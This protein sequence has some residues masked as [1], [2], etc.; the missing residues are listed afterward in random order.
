L[1]PAFTERTGGANPLNGEDIGNYSTVS[2]G[3]VDGD[4]DLDLVMGELNGK[5]R[6]FEASSPVAVDLS[7]SAG[8]GTETGTTVITVTATADSA[9][10]GAQTVTVAAS[11]TGITA[12]DFTLS[13][14]TITIADGQTIGTVTFTIVDD[15]QIEGAETATLTISN[16][17]ASITLGST[18][19]QNVAIT[20]NDSSG[21]VTGT[22]PVAGSFT[23]DDDGAG[24]VELRD[25]GG[26]LIFSTPDTGTIVINGTAGDDTLTIDFAGGNLTAT[27]TFNGLGQAG[28]G[29]ALVLTGG[30]TFNTASFT[31]DSLNDGSIDITGNGTISYTGLEP[32]TSTITATNVTLNLPNV[33]NPDTVLRDSAAAG[34]TELVGSTFETIAFTNPT[35]SLTI[36]GG[37]AADTISIEGLDAAWVADLNILATGV[38]D[39]STFQTTATD[40]G[41]G[42]LDV[43]T[44][45]ITVD[46]GV[47]TN[48]GS[49]ILV[50]INKTD[51]DINAAILT[52]GGA[53]DVSGGR[54][55]GFSAS[56]SI[57]TEAGSTAT[58][59]IQAD[60]LPT[61]V[62]GITMA[63][64]SFVD[65]WGGALTVL[66][67]DD[68]A[69][70]L[71]RSSATVRITSSGGAITD[72]DAGSGQDIDRGGSVALRAVT[73][74]G[75]DADGLET[76]LGTLAAVTESG[77]I[78]LTNTG[79]LIIGTVNGLS[80]VT[81]TDA[82]TND[83]GNDN[84][85]IVANSPLTV[86]QL[87]I[88]NDGGNIVLT[89]QGNAT[90]DDLTLDA[91]VTAT[92]GN[93]NITL[94]AGDSIL[95]GG[96]TD[97]DV[98][99][100]G[101]GAIDYNANDDAGTAGAGDG[102][103]AGAITMADG[104]QAS[105]GTGLI[106]M[107]AF[108]DIT[109]G[110]VATNNTTTAAIIVT[111]TNGDIVD[112]GDSDTFDFSA[113]SGSAR[114]T[115]TAATGIGDGTPAAAGGAAD[116][117]IE[118]RILD[119][120]ASVTGTG[121][122]DID[123]ND[124]IILSDVDTANGSIQVDAAG[125]VN[126]DDVESTT[127]ADANDIRI[128]TTTG[129][130][131]IDRINVG[132]GTTAANGDVI[133]EATAGAITE[134]NTVNAT[135]VVAGGFRVVA[136]NG[137]VGLTGNLIETSISTLEGSSTGGGFFVTNSRSFA[138]ND[139]ALGLTDTTDGATGITSAGTV[140]LNSTASGNITLE[141]PVS[142]NAQLVS[143]NSN[144]S[145]V[146]NASDAAR[147]I[148]INTGAAGTIALRAATGIGTMANS[149]EIDA[150]TLAFNNTT[151]GDVFITDRV[152]GIVIN[153][154]DG[155]TS[156]AGVNAVSIVADNIGVTTGNSVRFSHNTTATSATFGSVVV[157][158]TDTLAQSVDNI[159]VDGGVTVT[160]GTVVT[161]AAGDIA[162]LLHNS[163][164][165]ASLT[166]AVTINIDGANAG[167]AD[168]NSG[169]IANLFGNINGGSVVVNGGTDADTILVYPNDQ[170]IVQGVADTNMINAPVTVDGAEGDDF[171][172]IHNGGL[173]GGAVD[174][175]ISD[176]GTT[177][178]DNAVVYHTSASETIFVH[179]N[180]TPP[181]LATG[182]FINNDATAGGTAGQRVNYTTTLNRI[183]SNGGLFR[184]GPLDALDVKDTFFV[185][186]SQTARISIHGNEG[187]F[188]GSI[189][190]FDIL[191]FDSYNNP[192]SIIGK[193][194][195]TAG[196]PPAFLG[197]SFRNIEDLPLRPLGDN[198]GTNAAL[199]F[200]LNAG[201]TAV[202][203]AQSPTET[204]YTSMFTDTFYGV[205]SGAG[206]STFGWVVADVANPPIPSPFAGFD[207]EVGT[208]GETFHDLVRDGHVLPGV[209]TFQTDITNGWYLVSV[210]TKD[211]NSMVVTDVFHTLALTAATT[212]PGR[213]ETNFPVLVENG[214]LT[215]SFANVTP[216]EVLG[217][218]IRPGQ[219]L[220]IGSPEPG[221]LPADGATIDQFTGFEATPGDIITISASLDT[222]GDDIPD[223]DLEVTSTDIRPDLAGVQV[224]ADVNGQYT[225]N[226]RR[227]TAIGTAFI[228]HGVYSGTQTGCTAVDYV[229]VDTRR[230][231]FES[232]GP[233]STTQ[234]PVNG[235]PT[236]LPTTEVGGYISV[237]S[238]DLFSNDLGYGWSRV[239]GSFGSSRKLGL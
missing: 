238:N 53:V 180:V 23:L 84:I 40:T 60:D 116:A 158:A 144:G 66:A 177:T 225:Y 57:D 69:V 142:A 184:G 13:N 212:K 24:N 235:F 73:G 83:T 11:G 189:A 127:D 174:V 28:V 209:Q 190:N 88:D 192:F 104:T 125:A 36:N 141:D 21:D 86:N 106:T 101:S 47:D 182:G 176:T 226:I 135:E 76:T 143:I 97:S 63:D 112:G 41:G 181:T 92:G 114:V 68:I 7:V 160:A 236:N 44:R 187:Q 71:L 233:G 139:L 155:L 74:I 149:L 217:I 87:V 230:F 52:G 16:P 80:G 197:V 30:G 54:D 50:G 219:L 204:N 232:G 133:V 93:G 153:D 113:S 145:I 14:T 167:N 107:D 239:M 89:S 18:T 170:T 126:A 178:G 37:T 46:V 222:N 26:V 229:G 220:T 171:Y 175:T 140:R 136:G 208:A 200:D 147:D 198:G 25:G 29:D 85:T 110:N 224:L 115:L 96:T 228:L 214:K 58:V 179:N 109:V 148:D 49:L 48:G 218:E 12:G 111:S 99:A 206:V 95:Q 3:D 77:D 31:F 81:I 55:V 1:A 108:G 33:V 234:A 61:N 91:D 169:G 17:S 185:Q 8:T 128:T 94:N 105:S 163:T 103:G 15:F 161:L 129:N 5:F 119:L 38:G 56:G 39:T 118:T 27:I 210:K 70:S 213:A 188:G 194:I 191:D 132:G 121:S 42:D 123:E 19:T 90:T 45:G 154:V 221:A 64:G 22:L 159:Q 43:R 164:V 215:I 205:D 130:V 124:G 201:S 146:S 102:S 183:E 203:T 211:A 122:I 151:S 51:I 237:L 10:S 231:D 207:L 138:V 2:L 162:N 193:T 168:V 20:D 173:N 65:A 79:A 227:P 67:A 131:R 186:P 62:G 75:S 100:S 134:T 120:D 166:M 59:V 32:I 165:T 4:G 216:L 9:V 98:T 6:F 78:V 202:A 172:R 34:Q 82:N 196:G 117:A 152:T 137:D 156:S 35:D 195:F 223:I 150:G 72:A 199:R 157:T